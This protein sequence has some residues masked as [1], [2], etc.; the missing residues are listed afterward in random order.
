MMRSVS[1]ALLW[2]ALA[3]LPAGC[4]YPDVT[5]AEIP[6]QYLLKYTTDQGECRAT[7][8]LEMRKDGTYTETFVMG[9]VKKTHSATW[10]VSDRVHD[11]VT[12]LQ[13]NDYRQYCDISNYTVAPVPSIVVSFLPV[14]RVHGVVCF[15]F[16]DDREYRFVKMPPPRKNK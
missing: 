10:S 4:E 5:L 15:P 14:A 3:W 6:G 16:D 9:K 11:H 2:A 13:L 8:I 12:L 1:I 7:E